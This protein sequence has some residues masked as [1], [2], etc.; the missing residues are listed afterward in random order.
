MIK[1]KRCKEHEEMSV[2]E[3]LHLAICFFM[4]IP[5]VQMDEW[6]NGWLD[7]HLWIGRMDGLTL[8]EMV[9]WVSWMAHLV[10]LCRDL[11]TCSIMSGIY[12][13]C[14]IALALSLG[15]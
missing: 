8:M 15:T 7:S 9:G 1:L 10:L 12:L 14:I 2:I 5:I 13:Y 6:M 3:F 11:T 4:S